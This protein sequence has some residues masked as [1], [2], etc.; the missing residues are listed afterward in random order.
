MSEI[1][2]AIKNENLSGGESDLP[3]NLWNEK[4]EWHLPMDGPQNQIP[5]SIE[6]GEDGFYVLRVRIKMHQDDQSLDPA[7]KAWFWFD[8]GSEEGKIFPFPPS[9]IPK[10][11]NWKF[12]AMTLRVP[13][14]KVTHIKGYILDHSPQAGYWNK[15]VDVDNISLRLL[16]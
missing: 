4:T 12:H 14:P 10:S 2:S 11:G 13:D 1:E 9:K 15:H 16:K 3:G 5:F 7:V 8:D 6:I